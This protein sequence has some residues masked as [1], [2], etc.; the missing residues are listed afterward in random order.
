MATILP[1]QEEFVLIDE[2]YLTFEIYKKY[3]L[4]M[5]QALLNVL[6]Q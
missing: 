5:I 1:C 3:R 6:S 2:Q 4:C